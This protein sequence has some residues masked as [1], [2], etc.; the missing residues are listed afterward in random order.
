MPSQS[1]L[2]RPEAWPTAGLAR[3]LPAANDVRFVYSHRQHPR[4][5]AAP[6]T[7]HQHPKRGPL[8]DQFLLRPHTQHLREQGCCDDRLNS[9][10][11][12][13]TGCDCWLGMS[14]KACVAQLVGESVEAA[15]RT[16]ESKVVVVVARFDDASI[17]DTDDEDAG[18]FKRFVVC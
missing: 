8:I 18:Q 15:E 2:S 1:H 11:S 5:P 13:G 9:P 14:A 4:P 12:Y 10:S 7:G 16:R 6:V 17:P 3:R